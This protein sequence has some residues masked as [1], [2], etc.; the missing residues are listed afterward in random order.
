MAGCVDEVVGQSDAQVATKLIL[1]AVDEC[2]SV[3]KGPLLESHFEIKYYVPG[4][5][6]GVASTTVNPQSRLIGFSRIHKIPI[7][8]SRFF[9]I[10][11]INTWCIKHALIQLVP[12]LLN[13]S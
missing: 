3:T 2:P 5:L 8:Y 4:S 9:V 11:A 6:P 10:Q 13:P 7:L 12:T 1:C